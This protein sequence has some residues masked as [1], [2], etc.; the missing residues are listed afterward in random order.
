MYYSKIATDAMRCDDFKLSK[1]G[2][3]FNIE[4]LSVVPRQQIPFLAQ[5][6]A[7]KSRKT[8]GNVMTS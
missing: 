1:I 5:Q 3:L 4:P 8:H 2:K 7:T 6:L